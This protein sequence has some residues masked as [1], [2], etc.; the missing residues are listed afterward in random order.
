MTSCWAS[1]TTARPQFRDIIGSLEQMLNHV[2]SR[3]VPNSRRTSLVPAPNPRRPEN[4]CVVSKHT[5]HDPRKPSASSFDG[6]LEYTD[7]IGVPNGTTCNLAGTDP[8][9]I[10]M[11]TWHCCSLVT[12]CTFLGE[13][14]KTS[15]LTETS[16]VA[17]NAAGTVSEP[18]YNRGKAPRQKKKD[19]RYH[20]TGA[21]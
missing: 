5:T 20:R 14:G 7:L 21:K 4:T 1:C 3:S 17:V 6:G 18:T 10:G 8:G 15:D 16:P 19:F 2:D 12:Y 13:G 9:D 11:L